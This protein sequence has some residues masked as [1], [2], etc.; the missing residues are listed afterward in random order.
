MLPHGTEA[1]PHGRVCA[2]EI[3]CIQLPA[4]F[5]TPTK[6]LHG[7]T[8]ESLTSLSPKFVVKDGRR[9]D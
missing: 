4:I 6:V 1:D 3:H 5:K 2:H 7:F 9:A 8:E